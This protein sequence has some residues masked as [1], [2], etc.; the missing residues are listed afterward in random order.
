LDVIARRVEAGQTGAVWQRRVFD[1]ALRHL[2]VVDA[3][4][5]VT[6]AYRLASASEAPVH[7]WVRP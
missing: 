7:A 1:D 3:G 4:R 6:R 5:V 2:G